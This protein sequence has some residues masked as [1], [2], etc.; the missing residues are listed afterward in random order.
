MIKE[1]DGL[2]IPKVM[3]TLWTLP[4][5]HS[6]TQRKSYRT[7]LGLKLLFAKH[8]KHYPS[9]FGQT[10]LATVVANFTILVTNINFGPS[11]QMICNWVGEK[12]KA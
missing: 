2:D 4:D 9:R 10:S 3:S 5:L 6:L 7:L 1:F 12:G 8:D 11:R